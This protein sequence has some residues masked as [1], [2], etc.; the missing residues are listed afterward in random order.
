MIKRYPKELLTMKVLRT[1]G[2]RSMQGS[3]RVPLELKKVIDSLA[4]ID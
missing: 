3:K 2:V 1:F 4:N